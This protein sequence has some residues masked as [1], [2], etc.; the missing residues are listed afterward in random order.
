[1][2]RR[3]IGQNP[4]IREPLL[5]AFHDTF[6][7]TEEGW[8][9]A[10]GLY[11]PMH[12]LYDRFIVAAGF[13]PYVNAPKVRKDLISDIVGRVPNAVQDSLSETFGIAAGSYKQIAKKKA[14]PLAGGSGRLDEAAFH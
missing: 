5:Q 6:G 10:I 3:G 13:Q 11:P 7:G 9:S 12:D 14:M 2:I 4:Y 1:M 8:G